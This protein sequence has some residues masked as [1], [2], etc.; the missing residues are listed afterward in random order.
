[1]TNDTA[2]NVLPE[3]QSVPVASEFSELTVHVAF[4]G[5]PIVAETSNSKGEWAVQNGPPFLRFSMQLSPKD[6]AVLEKIL[7][8]GNIA[9]IG[10]ELK[11]SNGQPRVYSAVTRR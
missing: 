8:T 7:E 5:L 11:D 4:D 1:M 6:A 10:L 3:T 2:A 9:L